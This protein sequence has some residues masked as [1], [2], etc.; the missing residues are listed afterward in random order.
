MLYPPLLFFQMLSE[1]TAELHVSYLTYSD[2]WIHSLSKGGKQVYILGL[3]FPLNPESSAAIARDKTATSSL[4]LLHGVSAVPH[5]LVSFS[6]RYTLGT[7]LPVLEKAVKEYGYPLVVKPNTGSEGRNV[8]MVDNEDMLLAAVKTIHGEDTSAC[9]CPFVSSEVEYRVVV[10]DGKALLVLGKRPQASEW[11]HNITHG[12]VPFVHIPT[13]L[14]SKLHL[15]ATKATQAIAL[16]VA[17]VDILCDRDGSLFVLE[18]NASVSL[19]A[20]SKHSDEFYKIAKG[21]YTQLVKASLD[22]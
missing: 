9:V 3:H 11:R 4:L 7:Y 10:L 2:N 18:V 19:L 13:D 5:T 8:V 17:S 15:L 12:A 21:V 22:L 6:A 20:F 14:E 16:R 1:I